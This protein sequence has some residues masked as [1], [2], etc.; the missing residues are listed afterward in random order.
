MSIEDCFAYTITEPT[1]LYVPC[2]G[3]RIPV[4]FVPNGKSLLCE[5]SF[6]RD[7]NEVL[8]AMGARFDW[9]NKQWK[10][11]FNRRNKFRLAYF[12]GLD[13]YTW[14][15]RPHIEENPSR[16]L[17]QHQ[18]LMFRDCI[19]Y[20]RCIQA[21]DMG[22]GKTLVAIEAMEYFKALWKLRDDQIWYLG[23]KA[24]IRSV[25]LELI[26]WK[27]KVAPVCMT[28]NKVVDVMKNWTGGAAPRI[29]IVDESS[30]V[31]T[32]TSQR[33]VAVQKIADSMLDEWG[34]DC[35]VVLLSGTPAP[36][37]PADWWSQCEIAMP[38]Y[39]REGNVDKFKARLA[40]MK[41]EE[42]LQ[43]GTFPKLITWWDDEKKCAVC[44]Q[45]AKDHMSTRERQAPRIGGFAEVGFSTGK[46]TVENNKAIIQSD[47]DFRPSK[48]EV[49]NLFTRLKGMVRV[50]FKKDCTDLP[51]KIYEIIRLKPTVD[52]VRAAAIIK[53]TATRAITAL[54]ELRE[55]SDGFMY[56]DITIGD[57]TCTQCGGTGQC[58]QYEGEVDPM[59]P[60]AGTPG[61]F[62]Q[63]MKECFICK[64]KGTEPIIERQAIDMGSPK[65][66]ALVDLLELYEDHG[67]LIVWGGFEGTLD[68]IEKICEKNKWIVLRVDGHG[69]RASEGY[70]ANNL[71]VAMDLSHVDY[72]INRQKYDKIVVVANP[73]AG[74][75]AYTW[76][77]ACAEVYYSNDFDG[78]ARIQS[79]DR[80]HRIG[81]DINKGLTIYDL[82]CLPTDEFVLNN[83]KLKRKLQ[84]M[85]MGELP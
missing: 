58:M 57:R 85:T 5:F 24:A 38:G 39:I 54:T 45:Y 72:A 16:P 23:P 35:L 29:M 26:K 50:T 1:K 82:F 79:E 21:A 20:R 3:K 66:E 61:D 62:K 53:K 41:Q 13:A 17:R 10:L 76:T 30:K 48:N 31:K 81:M 59:A 47:H 46:G 43:G 70:L 19:T 63:V 6:N 49:A 75:M 64:G 11:P 67:R 56:K 33:T 69:L 78:E 84:N 73:K 74:G 12:A 80:A 44:G 27:A 8:K 71:L 28:Y 40:M 52:M 14:Y 22:T 60:N 51:D 7:M 9:D 65:D 34:I 32:A 68:R 77:A 36:K 25:G 42:S 83:L 18:L 37:S 4:T 15:E 55:L 2:A